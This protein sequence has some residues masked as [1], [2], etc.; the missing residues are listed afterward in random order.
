GAVEF[1]GRVDHQV[2][3]RGY[4]IELGEIESV[5]GAVAGVRDV[6]ALVHGEGSRLVACYVPDGPDVGLSERVQRECASRLPEYMIPADLVV[7]ESIPLNANGKVDRAALAASMTGGGRV[8]VDPRT[9]LERQLAEIWARVLNLD[10]VSVVDSFFD[11]GGHSISAI[12][13]VG[14]LR[15]A[16]IPA[17]VRDVFLHRTVAA[18][19]ANLE[20]ERTPAEPE[21]Q[22]VAPFALLDDADRASLPAGL[23]DAYPI[24]Q[25]QLG[26]LV[27]TMTDTERHTYHNVSAFP[28]HDEQPL[29]PDALRRAVQTVVD[30]HE[31]LRTSFDLD[32][33]SVPLQLVHAEVPI[34]VTELD[35]RGPDTEARMSAFMAAERA[36]PF[37]PDQV[38]QMRV[39]GAI[40]EGSAWW[41]VLTMSHGILEGWSHHS[42]LMEILNNYRRLRDINAPVPVDA[43]P[44]RYADF[45]A[46]ELAALTSA[47]DEAYW[48]GV[49]E[50]PRFALPTGWGAP[51]SDPQFQCGTRVPLHDLLDGLRNLASSTG[52]ALKSVLLAAHLKVMSQIT[53]EPVFTSGLVCHGRPEVTGADQ[54]YGMHLNTLPIVHRGPAAT[55]TELIRQTF[56]AEL[57]LWPHR[58]YPLPSVQR[59]TDGDRPIEI[60]F[61]YLDFAQVDTDRVGFDDAVYEASS[62]FDLHVS[63]LDGTLSI[64]SDPHVVSY[65]NVLRLGAM[66]R[67]VLEAMVADPGAD[68]R[69]VCLPAGEVSVLLADG[70]GV[71]EPLS[72]SVPEWFEEQVSRVPSA[73]A[74]NGV[75][76][77]ELDARAADVG[78]WLVSRG[79]SR[80][81]V[82]GVLLDR[83][84][85]LVAA[86]L[87]VWKAGAAFVPLDPSYPVGRVEAM[88][89]DAGASVLVTSSGY[90]D[91][92]P[93]GVEVLSVE[94]VPSAGSSRMAL[95]GVV[96]LD[97]LAYVIFTS[98]ST[99]RP[100][101]VQVTHRG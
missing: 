52:T 32:G 75:P 41:F 13:L 34:E 55:W 10:T 37:A 79:V 22:P 90:A 92:R 7:V 35:L 101:G 25:V 73:V 63:T 71:V 80:G 47:E 74:V 64:L 46:A 38:P 72:G 53:V 51:D 2:K 97:D 67:A 78:S 81:S 100:K 36:N 27:K 45:V 58:H 93:A 88:L 99:G 31:I 5:I 15:T 82:V 6:V 43:L 57:E 50:Y 87:G 9:D 20:A 60:L 89:V 59:F 29:V 96:D 83:G 61:N 44:V 26:M 24:A 11:L 68:A 28:I 69:V 98:G 4:R 17:S 91:R 85:D 19:A 84:V 40:G 62:E 54:V 1:V 49:V 42:L 76:F 66:Y 94:V 8:H 30:R 21:F 65:P 3:V 56:D 16:G 39:A 77:A 12:A 70:D 48:R 33:Y 14:A 18:L 95:P 23:T 86:L